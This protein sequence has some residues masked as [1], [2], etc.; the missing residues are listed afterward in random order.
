ME[1][2]QVNQERKVPPTWIP[3]KAKIRT[4]F[5]RWNKLWIQTMVKNKMNVF[6]TVLALI[7]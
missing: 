7:G 3:V 4:D 2:F 1:N 6:K 5:C